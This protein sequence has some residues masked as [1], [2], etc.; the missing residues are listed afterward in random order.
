MRLVSWSRNK[1]ALNKEQNVEKTVYSTGTAD[2]VES[3]EHKM[4]T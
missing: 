1:N 4:S 2:F 3:K